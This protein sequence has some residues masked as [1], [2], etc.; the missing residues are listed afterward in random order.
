M[1]TR[2]MMRTAVLGAAILVATVGVAR[3]DE[4][5]L[6]TAGTM[7]DALGKLA[8]KDVEIVLTN[9]KSYRG[10]V[11]SVGSETVLVTQI[12]GKEFYD[13]LIELDEVAAVEVRVRGN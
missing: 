7:R 1:T 4:A 2:S 9:G 12:A 5:V 11:G 13:V 3:A 10:K 8:G 6:G